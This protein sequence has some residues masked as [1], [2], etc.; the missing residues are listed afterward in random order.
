[1]SHHSYRSSAPLGVKILAAMTALDGLL[2]LF[3]GLA[4]LGS[5]LPLGLFVSV[6]GIVQ[7][8]V[9]YGLWQLEPY[10]YTW[11]LGLFGLSA[12]LDLFIGNIHGAGISIINIM[13]LYHFRGLYRK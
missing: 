9:S 8:L 11:G 12:V 2:S 1:M 7:L 13:I 10:A 6:V 3:A 4:L 5:T